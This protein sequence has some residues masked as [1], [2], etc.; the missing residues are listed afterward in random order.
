VARLDGVIEV[1]SSDRSDRAAPHRPSLDRN[2]SD[3][4]SM[5]NEHQHLGGGYT[6]GPSHLREAFSDSD[7]SES[8]Q[9]HEHSEFHDESTATTST[10]SAVSE[11]VMPPPPQ[12]YSHTA[13]ETTDR[14][15][16]VIEIPKSSED[17]SVTSET[18]SDFRSDVTPTNPLPTVSPQVTSADVLS[19][20]PVKRTY[21]SQTYDAPVD[22]YGPPRPIVLTVGADAD[23]EVRTFPFILCLT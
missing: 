2:Y 22:R 9:D 10:P 3:T 11:A 5:R 4:M 8:F 16:R 13:T 1:L 20:H 12:L 23:I 7:V 18:V 21:R 17:M 19:S 14:I 15:D 6:P